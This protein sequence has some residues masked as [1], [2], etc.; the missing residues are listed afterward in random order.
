MNL[1][2]AHLR[3]AH[4]GHK[5]TSTNWLKQDSHISV[6]AVGMSQLSGW[7]NAPRAANG[8]LLWKK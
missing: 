2:S 7:A 3:P 6:R 1:K 8:T 4:A 5:R